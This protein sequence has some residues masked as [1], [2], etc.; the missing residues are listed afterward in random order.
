MNQRK[1]KIGKIKKRKKKQTPLFFRVLILACFFLSFLFSIFFLL[2]CFAY[3]IIMDESRK[4]LDE[5]MGINRNGD[6][7]ESNLLKIDDP[8]VCRN[9]L[10]GF[11]PSEIFSNTKSAVS[12]SSFSFLS[13]SFFPFFELIFFVTEPF[14]FILDPCLKKH[15]ELLQ[16]EYQ[17]L[18]TQGKPNKYGYEFDFIQELDD[19]IE[20]LDQRVNRNKE[21]IAIDREYKVSFF[22]LGISFLNKN[23]QKN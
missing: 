8:G 3:S 7:D 10:C 4:L 5:L 12:L 6:V 9:Y 11:C 1:R 16:K 20:A 21:R 18:L 14:F 17:G 2:V 23:D 15:D 19:L 22:F 13:F